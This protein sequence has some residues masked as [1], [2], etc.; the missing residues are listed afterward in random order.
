MAFLEFCNEG[1]SNPILVFCE[2]F[3]LLQPH[4]F[5]LLLLPIGFGSHPINR[6]I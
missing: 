1:L 3:L 6:V 5:I 2:G 4:L